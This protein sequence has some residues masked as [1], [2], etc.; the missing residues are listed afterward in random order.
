MV[1]FCGRFYVIRF[2]VSNKCIDALECWEVYMSVLLFT[3]YVHIF[4]KIVFCLTK[5]NLEDNYFKIV[6]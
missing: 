1:F 5:Y 2:N 3:L 6:L 4:I